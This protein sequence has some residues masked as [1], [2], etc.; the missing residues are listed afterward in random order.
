VTRDRHGHP[1]TKPWTQL[2]SSAAFR[3]RARVGRPGPVRRGRGPHRRGRS[4]ATAGPCTVPADRRGRSRRRVRQAGHADGRIGP[5]L[6]LPSINAVLRGQ[7]SRAVVPPPGQPSNPPIR[8]GRY[9]RSSAGNCARRVG[10]LVDS[11]PGY[12][13]P[14]VICTVPGASARTGRYRDPRW[15]PAGNGLILAARRPDRTNSPAGHFEPCAVR[16]RSS[17]V[18]PRSTCP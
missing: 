17:W 10:A 6:S 15:G 16:G 11:R 12:L 3:P 2:A 5:G 13:S 14:S 7:R 1:T 4:R 8:L 9:A 18:L